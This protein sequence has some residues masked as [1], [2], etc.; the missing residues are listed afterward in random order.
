MTWRELA[1]IQPEFVQWVAQRHGG[2]PEGPIEDA[3]YE[4]FKAE[5]EADSSARYPRA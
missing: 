4:R 5:Y 2:L 3:D 1:A